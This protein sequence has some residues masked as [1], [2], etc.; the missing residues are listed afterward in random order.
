MHTAP[1]YRDFVVRLVEANPHTRKPKPRFA[2][3]WETR[4]LGLASIVIGSTMLSVVA[5]GLMG[6]HINGLHDERFARSPRTGLTVKYQVPNRNGALAAVAGECL[7]VA[8]IVLSGWRRTRTP[9]LCLLGTVIC[10]VHIVATLTHALVV[11]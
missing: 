3:S 2:E 9:L 7:G 6:V 1:G 11:H 8:G 5:L 4:A 10:L